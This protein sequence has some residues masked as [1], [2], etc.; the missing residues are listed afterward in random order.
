MDHKNKDEKTKKPGLL[1]RIIR[2]G[3]AEPK[4]ELNKLPVAGDGSNGERPI[5]SDDIESM[6][7]ALANLGYKL[8][9]T[10]KK[11][12]VSNLSPELQ[13]KLEEHLF[14]PDRGGSKTN[15]ARVRELTDLNA[16]QT[17]IFA[18]VEMFNNVSDPD[19]DLDGLM[20]DYILDVCELRRSKGRWFPMQGLGILSLKTEEEQIAK[21]LH[22]GGMK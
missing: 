1:G 8:V 9:S 7:L 18:I 10:G 15:R 13:V 21:D 11:G 17:H 2:K 16:M 20:E 22:I 14:H 19:Y 5:S 6:Q 12:R 3:P 4:P